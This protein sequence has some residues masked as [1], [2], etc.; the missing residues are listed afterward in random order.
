MVESPTTAEQSRSIR[1]KNENSYVLVVKTVTT[2]GNPRNIAEKPARCYHRCIDE[3]AVQG[4]AVAELIAVPGHHLT[5]ARKE[6]PV[7]HVQIIQLILRLLFVHRLVG[8][9]VF[10]PG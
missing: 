5:Q 1:R 3:K 7:F 4:P 2:Y 6:P 8:I 9:V 10:L